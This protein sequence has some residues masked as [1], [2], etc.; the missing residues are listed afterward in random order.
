M[1]IWYLCMMR[2]HVFQKTA[3]VFYY[4]INYNYNWSRNEEIT[5]ERLIRL[6]T[7]TCIQLF[8]E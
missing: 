7:Y 5:Q 2:L 1:S 6:R 4:M 3:F 8:Y